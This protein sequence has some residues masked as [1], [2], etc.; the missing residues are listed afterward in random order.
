MLTSTVDS[1]R[2]SY[3]GQVAK[4]DIAAIS[5]HHR[6]QASPGYRAAA[7]YVLDELERAGLQATIEI[8]P[9][10]YQTKF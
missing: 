9:A 4:D 2:Q 7:E 6:I 3:S 10:D 1:I 8:Y 5:R